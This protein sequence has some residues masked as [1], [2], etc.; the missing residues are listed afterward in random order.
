MDEKTAT[1]RAYGIVDEN[2]AD[3]SFYLRLRSKGINIVQ[4]E[5]GWWAILTA[6]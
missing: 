3:D 1:L 2:W 6:M 4:A 5:L